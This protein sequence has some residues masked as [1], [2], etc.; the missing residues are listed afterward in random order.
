[1]DKQ[2]FLHHG[3]RFVLPQTVSVTHPRG[4]TSEKVSLSKEPETRREA[5]PRHGRSE[6]EAARVP[7][8]AWHEG[9]ALKST[10]RSAFKT[11]VIRLHS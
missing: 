8:K 9:K 11:G 3:E 6:R 4:R 1:M 5:L 10:K 2:R 7:E